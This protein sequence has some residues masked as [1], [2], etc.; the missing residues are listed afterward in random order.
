MNNYTL[1]EFFAADRLRATYSSVQGA[2][3]AVLVI[4]TGARLIV[5]T[6]DV[7]VYCDMARWELRQRQRS[8]E[9]SNLALNNFN[10]RP[11]LKYERAFFVDW[12]TADRYQKT[13]L[14]LIDYVVE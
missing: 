14:D 10:E 12:R 11:S 8:G 7:L 2:Q 13:L 5:Q 4:G 6:W 9:I 3:G 1:D